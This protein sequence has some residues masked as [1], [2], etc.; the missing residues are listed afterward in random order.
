MFAFSYPKMASIR[1]ISRTFVLSM[2]FRLSDHGGGVV[3]GRWCPL[4]LA[5]AYKSLL[6]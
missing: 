4:F 3:R 6:L 2:W 5:L 1:E